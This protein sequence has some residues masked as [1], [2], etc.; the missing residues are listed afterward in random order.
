[1]I[2]Y[3]TLR[4]LAASDMIIDTGIGELKTSIEHGPLRAQYHT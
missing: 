2:W 4:S 3:V 1:M